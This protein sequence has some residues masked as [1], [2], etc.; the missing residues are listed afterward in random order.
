LDGSKQEPGAGRIRQKRRQIYPLFNSNKIWDISEVF[1]DKLNMAIG[2]KEDW[3]DLSD[4]MPLII[5][6]LG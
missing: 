2:G 3:L 1:L 6:S 5:D 4:H